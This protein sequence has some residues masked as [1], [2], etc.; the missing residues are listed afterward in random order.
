M[1]LARFLV[2]I[3]QEVNP[4]NFTAM[5]KLSLILFPL[6]LLLSGCS[7]NYDEG[8]VRV[9]ND[10]YSVIV[11]SVSP[12]DIDEPCIRLRP[13]ESVDIDVDGVALVDRYGNPYT[14][15]HYRY[16]DDRVHVYDEDI[17]IRGYIT[18]VHIDDAG[19]IV[20]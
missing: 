6:V 4:L 20:E 3:W 9:Y 11:V 19:L 12:N 16:V 1:I 5:K 14:Y 10:S 17:D 7:Y 18:H 2:F 15:V 13:G 8:Y